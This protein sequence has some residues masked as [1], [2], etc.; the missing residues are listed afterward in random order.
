MTEEETDMI[1]LDESELALVAGGASVRI[2]DNGR[3]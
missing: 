1:E 2:D 3:S